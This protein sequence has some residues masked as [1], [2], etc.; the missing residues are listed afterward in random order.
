MMGISRIAVFKKVK[1]GQLAAIRFGRNWAVAISEIN[2]AIAAAA[3]APAG[4][5]K[6]PAASPAAPAQQA[7]AV[8]SSTESAEM[9]SIGWD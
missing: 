3:P 2:R 6:K 1:K 9:D 8:Q 5:V 4:S 7:P